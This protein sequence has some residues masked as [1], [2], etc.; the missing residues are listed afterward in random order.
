MSVPAWFDILGLDASSPEDRNG[1]ISCCA[2]LESI[3]Q[4]ELGRGVSADRIVLGGFSQGGAAAL[5]VALRTSYRIAGC[6][7][8]SAW[9][10]LRDSYPHELGLAFQNNMPIFQAHGNS[11]EAR[12]THFL[13]A[14]LTSELLSQPFVIVFCRQVVSFN[15]GRKTCNVLHQ[16]GANVEWMQYTGLGHSVSAEEIKDL[17]AFLCRAIPDTKPEL[18]KPVESMNVKE[19]KQFITSMGGVTSDC[20]EKKD[21]VRRANELRPG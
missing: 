19:L 21:L 16:L 6:A 5:S 14:N 12:S 7:A 11:D 9:L 2:H 3:I 17:Q 15:F 18:E 10:P 20:I 13:I 4:S 1:I 8:L